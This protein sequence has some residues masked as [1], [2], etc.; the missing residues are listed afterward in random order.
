MEK[1]YRH[2]RNALIVEEHRFGRADQ[3]AF[4][5][6]NFGLYHWSNGVF[7]TVPVTSAIDS[8]SFWDAP[9]D[10]I[11]F[12]LL[13]SSRMLPGVSAKSVCSKKTTTRS[14]RSDEDTDAV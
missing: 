10:V 5:T 13:E 7:P 6:I 12:T 9:V 11:S 1:T 4:F 2:H 8:A 14:T 3:H